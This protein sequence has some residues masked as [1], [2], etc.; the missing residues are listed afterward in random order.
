MHPVRTVTRDGLVFDLT[1]AG[2]PGGEPVV[3]LHGFPQSARCWDAVTP[4]L[5]AAGLCTVAPDQRGY[6]PG[7]RPTGRAAY[8]L[9][10]L[11]ADAAAV[12][13]AVQQEYG[14]QQCG[15]HLVGH[16]W[17]A[18]VAWALAGLRPELVRTVT[19]LSVPPTGAF[20]AALRRPRQAVASWY[21]AAFQVPGLAERRFA[22]PTGRPWSPALVAMLVRSGQTRERAERDAAGMADPGALTAALNWYRA[23]PL[24]RRDEV[25]QVSA[26][27]LYVWSDGDTAL[28]RAAA[29]LAPRNVAGP[30]RY[31][32]LRGVSHWIP[33]EAPDALAELLVDH[34]T[35]H[36]V[37]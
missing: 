25:P 14:Q 26:P 34:V 12:V 13:E 19:G 24:S 10:E 37:Q 16:D 18:V 30:F 28:T 11:V 4:A 33:D 21:M 17:G 27:A 29:E 23:L 2:P 31:V 1:T 32:E 36:P 6:S 7:A 5:T 9:P 22:A 35:A 20:R 8:R 3:L 15:V